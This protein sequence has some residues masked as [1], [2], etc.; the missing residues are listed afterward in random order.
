MAT[1]RINQ[2]KIQDFSCHDIILKAPPKIISKIAISKGCSIARKVL[3][4]NTMTSIR[5]HAVQLDNLSELGN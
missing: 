4:Q 1:N 5:T 3:H 2:T